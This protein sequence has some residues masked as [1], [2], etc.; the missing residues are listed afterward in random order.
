MIC[1]LWRYGE[2]RRRE[3]NVM[4]GFS[5]LE[6][7][8]VSCDECFGWSNINWIVH[9]EGESAYIAFLQPTLNHTGFLASISFRG[10]CPRQI[11]VETVFVTLDCIRIGHPSWYS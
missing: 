4:S 11:F 7:T 8:L 5:K 3:C 6:G 9:D 10:D 1:D 2:T